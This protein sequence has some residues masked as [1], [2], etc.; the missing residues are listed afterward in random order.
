LNAP[1]SVVAHNVKSENTS[2]T[3]H[4]QKNGK[5]ISRTIEEYPILLLDDVYDTHPVCEEKVQ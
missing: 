3:I 4:A 1:I 2:C 5:S